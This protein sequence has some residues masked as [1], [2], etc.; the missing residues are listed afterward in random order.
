VEDVKGEG[1]LTCLAY[2]VAGEA[3]GVLIVVVVVV[4][5][6]H[7]EVCVSWKVSQRVLRF[8]CCLSKKV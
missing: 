7:I 6:R 3:S 8:E 5:V 2:S 1:S 4:V